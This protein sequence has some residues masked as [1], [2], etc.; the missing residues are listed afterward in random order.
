MGRIIKVISAIMLVVALLLSAAELSHKRRFGHFFGYGPHMD[1]VLGDSDVAS[2][3]TYYARLWNLSLS[4]FRIQGCR[5][6]GGYVGSGILYR[7]DVQKWEPSG[8]IWNSLRGADNWVADP[9]SGYSNDEGC[10]METTHVRPLSSRTVGWV[11]EDW[12]TTGAPVRFAIHTS[13]TT[14]PGNQ[15]ILYTDT[16]VV[17]RSAENV[18]EIQRPR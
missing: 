2:Q 11:Y 4:S 3:D 18:Q 14:P 16:F 10:R 13:L 6:P 1:V 17:R 12:V 15:Q 8:H 7:W 5:L 9:F